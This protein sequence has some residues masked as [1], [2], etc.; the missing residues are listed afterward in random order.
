M[1]PGGLLDAR[2]EALD[3]AAL[4][5]MV[6]EADYLLI[7]ETHANPCDHTAAAQILSGLIAAGIPFDLGLEMLPREQQSFLDAQPSRAKLM[8]LWEKHWGYPFALYAPIFDAILGHEI[9]LL[10]LN[11]SWQTAQAFRDGRI[12]PA[13]PSMPRTIIPPCPDQIQTLQRQF[14]L[15]QEMRDHHGPNFDS[16][17]QVQSLWDST[18]AE[19]AISWHRQT[20]RLVVIIAG[21]GH[22]ERG[23]GIPYRIQHLDPTARMVA[24]LPWRS[25]ENRED[26]QAPCTPSLRT[27]FFSCPTIQ[28]SRLGMALRF[29]AEG[30]WIDAIDPGSRAEAAGLQ[31]GD[32][33]LEAAGRPVF[34][35]EDLHAAAME[36]GKSQTPLTLQVERD[37]QK[38][39]LTI[40]R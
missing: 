23:W 8:E 7:G 12:S 11:V 25:A 2:G 19:T 17:I 16:F 37:G 34:S 29:E 10:A 22:V 28:R 26:A 9:R 27:I 6:R 15:H 4:M 14:T 24:I 1:R 21:S 3:T 5:E 40:P 13:H 30:I 31:P 35:A 33:I 18:M 38:F 36:A 32:R 20:Q 39:T